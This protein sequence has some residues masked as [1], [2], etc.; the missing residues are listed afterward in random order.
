MPDT[1]LPLTRSPESDSGD[2][3]R[4]KRQSPQESFPNARNPEAAHA[5]LLLLHGCWEASH[6]LIDDNETPEGC[7][8]HAIVHRIEPDIGNSGYWFRRVGQHSIFSDI[9]ERAKQFLNETPIRGWTLKP[10]WDP[11]LFNQW[12]EEARRAPGSDKEKVARAI[13]QA[14]FDLLYAWCAAPRG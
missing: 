6:N 11:Y 13:Q 2:A 1:V 5:A 3:V 7:Y 14:E 4:L 9:H 8:V 10:S 12:C